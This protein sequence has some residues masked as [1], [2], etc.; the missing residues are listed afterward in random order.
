MGG[1]PAEMPGP[2]LPGGRQ[3]QL[4]QR[5]SRGPPDTERLGDRPIRQNS[6]SRQSQ[7]KT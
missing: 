5:T 6:Y 7:K 2:P 1:R 4:Q 3:Q